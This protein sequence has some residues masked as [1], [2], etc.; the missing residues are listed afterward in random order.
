[1]TEFLI[2]HFTFT[3][4]LKIISIEVLFKNVHNMSMQKQN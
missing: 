3:I 1:M 4:L 2:R